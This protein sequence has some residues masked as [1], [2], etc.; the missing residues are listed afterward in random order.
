[1]WG[2]VIATSIASSY[3]FA[4]YVPKPL[5]DFGNPDFD[6]GWITTTS[7]HPEA[8]PTDTIIKHDLGTND[9]FVYLIG[10]EDTY[11]VTSQQG[12]G[13]DPGKANF[14]GMFWSTMAEW[15]ATNAG[16]P[17]NNPLP[18]LNYIVVNANYP[19]IRV[20]IWKLP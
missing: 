1:M 2:L 6:S 9:I 11:Q 4:T 13:S 12:F 16:I 14:W 10:K 15:Q 18:Q 8:P 3:I 7:F 20:L 17:V 5:P 19:E